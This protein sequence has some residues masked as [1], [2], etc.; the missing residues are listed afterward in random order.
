MHGGEPNPAAVGRSKRR[1]LA[2]EN[3][4]WLLDTS[5]DAPPQDVACPRGF[6]RSPPS[7]GPCIDI[8]ATCMCVCVCARVLWLTIFALMLT[9]RVCVVACHLRSCAHCTCVRCCL[10]PSRLCSL[11]VCALLPATF[12]LVLTACFAHKTSHFARSSKKLERKITYFCPQQ[13]VITFSCFSV[14]HGN[15]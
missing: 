1:T 13:H 6:E 9:A 3:A 2:E 7:Y 11:H 10:P 15:G 8:G 5:P 12:A 4:L 14:S